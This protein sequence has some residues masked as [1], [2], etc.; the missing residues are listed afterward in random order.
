MVSFQRG[1]QGETWEEPTILWP[2]KP[3]I[4]EQ[5]IGAWLGS[6]DLHDL[7]T[8]REAL[9]KQG[10]EA[11]SLLRSLVQHDARKCR[12]GKQRL[13]LGLVLVLMA[14]LTLFCWSVI[15]PG[16]AGSAFECLFLVLWLASPCTLS[17]YEEYRTYGRRLNHTVALLHRISQ[18]NAT[19]EMI[20]ALDAGDS[21][22]ATLAAKSLTQLL[23]HFTETEGSRLE[24]KHQTALR[25]ALHGYDSALILAILQA[26]DRVLDPVAIREVRWLTNCPDW[27]A[28]SEKIQAAARASLAL[29]TATSQRQRT[30]QTLLRATSLLNVPENE[31]L[32]PVT[33]APPT[34][35]QHLLRASKPTCASIPEERCAPSESSAGALSSAPCPADAARFPF[36][37]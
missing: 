4:Q 10:P 1:R 2:R 11:S 24:A 29:L 27:I 15:Q 37:P 14:S 26:S 6:S 21:R 16:I 8:A 25:H 30:M 35:T 3:R 33:G 23:P 19:A 13:R 22:T 20:E 31:L 9:E 12:A 28:E 32:H 7:L 17:W 36:Y 5:C 18:P 34:E